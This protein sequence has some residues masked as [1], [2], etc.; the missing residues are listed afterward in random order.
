[1]KTFKEYTSARK[2]VAVQYDAETQKKL[3]EWAKENGFDLTVKYDGE[4]QDEKK[5]DFHTTVFYSTN[6]SNIRNQ[7]LKVKPTE[8]TIKGIKFLGEN[9][10]IPVLSI[11]L[12]EGIKDM[13]NYFE[14]IGLE[15]KWPSYE[16]HISISY[17]K[18]K[19]DVSKINLPDFK[20]KYDMLII[21]DIKE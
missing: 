16:P 8:V 2:Y 10:D 19:I 14:R 5:F 1:M 9:E 12:E 11:K 4:K 21:E 13:R 20:P 6:T 18:Q 17:A 3:R 15:D 7:T